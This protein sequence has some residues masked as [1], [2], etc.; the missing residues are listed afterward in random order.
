MFF[1]SIPMIAI[2]FGLS[3]FFIMKNRMVLALLILC[4]F[5]YVLLYM[6]S[7]PREIYDMKQGIVSTTQEASWTHILGLS[8]YYLFLGAGTLVMDIVKNQPHKGR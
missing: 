7:L 5:V 4:P 3:I 2:I 1:V 6:L 8:V